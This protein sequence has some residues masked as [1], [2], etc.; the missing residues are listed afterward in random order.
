MK[1]LAEKNINTPEEYLRI[2]RER[3]REVVDWFDVRRWKKLIS[4]FNGG[5]LLDIGCLDALTPFL[6]KEKHPNAEVWGLDFI[7]ELIKELQQNHEGIYWTDGDA[8]NLKF[9]DHY[10]N[11]V[12]MGELIEHLEFPD[13]AIREAFRVLKSGGI[14]ALSTPLGETHAGEVDK[15][16][17]LWGFTEHDLRILL[18]PYGDFK[19]TVL[20]SRVWPYKYQFPVAVCFVKKHGSA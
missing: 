2:Y 3:S 6:A 8:Y 14:L 16:R 1:R 13:K 17:H 19:M 15:E 20:G 12:I 11:Y 4:R 7:P 5:K 9:Q 10:F 18:S